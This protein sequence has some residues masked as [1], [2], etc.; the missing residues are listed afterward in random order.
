MNKG[1]LDIK[2]VFETAGI[3]DFSSLPD[4]VADRRKFA[5]LFRQLHGYLDSARVQG[6][7]WEKLVYEFDDD[8]VEMLFDKALYEILLMRYKE[9]NIGNG[10]RHIDVGYD[11]DPYLMSLPTDKIDAEYMNS[12][13]QKYYKLVKEEADEETKKMMLNELHKSF[14]LLSKEEQKFAHMVIHDIQNST[15]EY[16]ESKSIID[17]IAAYKSKAKSDEISLIAAYIGM[18]ESSLR[19][20]MTYHVTAN[21]INEFGRFDRL[22]MDIDIEV[23]HKY[24]EEKQGVSIP[25]RKI[26]PMIDRFL[27][28]FILEGII[29]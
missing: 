22:K 18:K 2:D 16:D 3:S 28:Q 8:V 15:L 13:F 4:D 1:F 14:A 17:Y 20:F 23:A 26:H 12:R 7:V 27:R 19:E 24:F 25:R 11:I 9:L 29:E 21:N 6:F 5:T 10:G